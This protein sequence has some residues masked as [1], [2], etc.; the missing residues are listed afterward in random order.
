MACD[1]HARG[2]QKPKVVGRLCYDG[3]WVK[4]KRTHAIDHYVVRRWPQLLAEACPNYRATLIREIE[5]IFE[6]ETNFDGVHDC[7]SRDA[8][9]SLPA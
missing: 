2:N 8:V 7:H 5:C 4:Q 3:R 6:V 1:T 9:P